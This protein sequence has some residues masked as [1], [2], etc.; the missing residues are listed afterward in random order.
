MLATIWDDAVLNEYS[1]VW[2]LA[3]SWFASLCMSSTLFCPTLFKSIM[4]A[5]C[6]CILVSKL[7]KSVYVFSMAV[8]QILIHQRV[9]ELLASV[10]AQI[11]QLLAFGTALLHNLLN[12]EHM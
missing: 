11:A 4:N 1:V 7:L 2:C 9:V 10:D 6:L 5:W 3:N 12:L 8:T